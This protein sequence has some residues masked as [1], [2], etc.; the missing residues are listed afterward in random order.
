MVNK[1]SP[2][3]IA[4][5]RKRA[6]RSAEP[7]PMLLTVLGDTPLRLL[8]RPSTWLSSPNCKSDRFGVMIWPGSKG[9][10]RLCNA[11]GSHSMSR[12]TA[13]NPFAFGS[14]SCAVISTKKLSST[15]TCS[16]ALPGCQLTSSKRLNSNPATASR[17]RFSNASI[18]K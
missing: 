1:E 7:S 15:T 12:A 5:N 8:I 14:N 6:K 9:A 13:A 17:K 4:R 11:L 2:G 3:C 18:C 10:S 16:I